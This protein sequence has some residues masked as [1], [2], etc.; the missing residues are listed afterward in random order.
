[1]A[2]SIAF[3]ID[4][5]YCVQLR[6]MREIMGIPWGFVLEMHGWW[7]IGSG[8]GVYYY[9]VLIEYLRLY[10]VIDEAKITLEWKNALFIPRLEVQDTKTK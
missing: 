2:G 8:L 6:A 4:R 5:N 3:D 1:V 9:I 7:H 10:L